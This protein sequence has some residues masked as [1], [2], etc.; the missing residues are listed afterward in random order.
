MMI[1]F[2]LIYQKCSDVFT[3]YKDTA[4][5]VSRWADDL[6]MRIRDNTR[7]ILL[8]EIIVLSYIID[9][10]CD[11]NTA[12]NVVYK[13]YDRLGWDTTGMAGF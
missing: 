12:A 1:D 8:D 3:E 2:E 6:Y 5:T 13:L 7:I 4:P 9:N 10:H 11:G